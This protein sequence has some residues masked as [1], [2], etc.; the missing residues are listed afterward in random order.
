MLRG[1]ELS[2]GKQAASHA[3]PSDYFRALVNV[4][5]VKAWRSRNS[6]YWQMMPIT[7]GRSEIATAHVQPTHW[8]ESGGQ[9]DVADR[10]SACNLQFVLFDLN[11]DTPT[12]RSV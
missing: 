9:A 10:F 12:V 5:R 2:H 11:Q 7:W 3:R 1:A 8:R 4:A 6:G